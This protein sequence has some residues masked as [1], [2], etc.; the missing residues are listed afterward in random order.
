[1]AHKETILPTMAKATVRFG[2]TAFQGTRISIVP[3]TIIL[4]HLGSQFL[5]LE[6]QV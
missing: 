2:D 6:G 5:D 1:M 3:A 4:L